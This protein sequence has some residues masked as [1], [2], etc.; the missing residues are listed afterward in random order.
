MRATEPKRALSESSSTFV[1]CQRIGHSGNAGLTNHASANLNLAR[2]AAEFTEVNRTV[3]GAR[4]RPQDVP[5]RPAE[6][7]EWLRQKPSLAELRAAFPGEWA[8]VERDV[9]ALVARDDA[10]EL[11]AYLVRSAS[12]VVPAPGHMAPLQVRMSAMIRQQM[13]IEAVNQAYLAASTGV[14]QGK[15]RFNLLNGYLM[16]KLLFAGDLQRKPVSMFW[17][18]LLWPLLGQRRLLMPLVRPK[19]IYCFYS[20]AL[21]ARLADLIGDRTC[22][23]IAAGDGTLTRFLIAA[24]VQVTATDDYSWGDIV[25]YPEQVQH[26]NA[27]K[28]LRTYKPEVVISSWTPPANAFERLVFSA[29]SVQTYI[30]IGSRHESAAGDWAAYRAQDSFTFAE[31]LGLSRLVLP[32]ENGG[33]VYVFQR[34]S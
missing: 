12:P 5:R 24:G 19:G 30:V 29:P 1:R 15:I 32:P 33:S 4:K 22:L 14:V 27:G 7:R 21:I 34:K 17:F 25:Q 23:E 13:T 9:A 3:A 18:R 11:K 31:D 2:V 8:T 28:A 26:Q 6:V 16:Q 20:G 10:E